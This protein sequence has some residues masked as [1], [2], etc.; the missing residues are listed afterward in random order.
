[1][2]SGYTTRFLRICRVPKEL[3]PPSPPVRARLPRYVRA[4]WPA[5]PHSTPLLGRNNPPSFSAD[6]YC[7]CLV[8]CISR[9]WGLCVARRPRVPDTGQALPLAKRCHGQLGAALAPKEVAIN[10]PL[11]TVLVY[12]AWRPPQSRTSF[13]GAVDT[14]HVEL[15]ALLYLVFRLYTLP[16]SSVVGGHMRFSPA[17]VVSNY[18]QWA[19]CPALPLG[20]LYQA[21]FLI[22]TR[23]LAFLAIEGSIAT[24]WGVTGKTIGGIGECYLILL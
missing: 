6:D 9:A 4:C 1:M 21:R 23:S 20:D 5:G 24:I 17:G 14:Q 3:F 13:G 18:A 22:E 19:F 2:R 12:L 7:T 11:V 8:I 15:L 10:L 16:E